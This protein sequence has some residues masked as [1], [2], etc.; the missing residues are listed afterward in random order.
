MKLKNIKDV[1]MFLDVVNQCKNDVWLT[2]VYGDKYNLK[3]QLSQYLGVAALLGN[4]AED[5][6]LYCES[7][8]D[9]TRFLNLFYEHP[10]LLNEG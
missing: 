4:H 7:H 6:E 9:E 1:D 5:L 8:D 3:S 10:E 2:S